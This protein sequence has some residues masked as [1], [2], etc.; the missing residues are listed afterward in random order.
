[1]E[2]VICFNLDPLD[3]S[4]PELYETQRYAPLFARLRAEDPIH[5]CRCPER[6]DHWSITR[7]DDIVTVER[8]PEVFSNA[9]ELGGI[10]LQDQAIGSVIEGSTATFI[11][12][13]PPD[14]TRY[15]EMVRPAFT[16]SHLRTLEAE[17]RARVS[18]ILDSLP[19][20]EA[21]D[22]V[23][24]VANELPIQMLATLFDMPQADRHRLLRWSNV[25]TGFDDPAVVESLEQARAEMREF[26][27]YCLSLWN[28]RAALPPRPDLIS[29]LVYGAESRTLTPIDYVSTMAL[30]TIGG[31]DTTRNSIT[32]GLYAF[33]QHPEQLARLRADRSL[34]KP[35]VNEILRWVTPVIHIRR[36][37]KADTL[38]GGKQIRQGDRVVL[39]Y[40]SAN[41]DE[42]VFEAPET[43]RIDR[44]GPRHLSFGTGIH[45]CVGARL[46]DMQL[47]ILWEELLERFPIIEVLGPPVRLRSNFIHGL[48][49]LPV[50]VRK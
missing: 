44:S 34:I 48:K 22:W 8:N 17:I 21:F 14:H 45:F 35:A 3:V 13:D 23:E 42:T 24:H 47:A 43:F 31:N 9:Y 12:M 30:L 49:T 10:R 11:S 26:S 5:F 29:M 39:W 37:A 16:P 25:M 1:M 40:V 36:T 15:R 28:E 20:G 19:I 38:L 50:R 6:G 7:Y 4:D 27:E 33:A 18:E 2:S 41:R 32:G 46:A